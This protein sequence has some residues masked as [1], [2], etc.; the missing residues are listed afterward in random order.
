MTSLFTRKKPDLY[1]S[2]VSA[3]NPTFAPKTP[4]YTQGLFSSQV[5]QPVSVAPQMSVAP[6]TIQGSGYGSQYASNPTNYKPTPPPTTPPPAPVPTPMSQYTK[7]IDD[8]FKR[9]SDQ[10]A[11]RVATEEASRQKNQ[12]LLNQRY[13]LMNDSIRGSVPVLQNNF[14]TFK[15]NTQADVADTVA[16]GERQKEQTRDYYGEAERT[17]AQARGETQAQARQK[18]AAQGAVDSR[19]AGS[20]TQA[21]EN[22]DSD[23]NRY[24]QK[25]SKEMAMKLTDIDSAVGQYQRQASTLIQ[26]EEAKLQESL[27]QIEFT[28][29][30]NEIAKEQAMNEAYQASQTRIQTIQD[31]L[32]G[33]EQQAITQKQTVQLELDKLAKTKFTPEFMATGVP[34]TQA[35]YEFMV[36]NADKM[37]E[38]GILPGGSQA[39]SN[40]N[41]AL[42]M[43]NNILQGDTKNITGAM[44]TG[45]V[46]ILSTLTGAVGKQTDYD[47]LKSLLA[48]AE[49]GQLKGSGTVSDFE[50]KML[51]KAAMAGL[52]QNLPDDEFRRRLTLLQQDLMSGGATANNMSM[53]NNIITAPDGQQVMIVD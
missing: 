1:Q 35:E 13:G 27:R 17:A 40:Q 50:A 49:R 37:K 33:I 43:V 20:Y 45:S 34:T 9:M 22:I 44:R 15:T 3:V 6:K 28:L 10:S 2:M 26:T 7:T 39:G 41:K 14:N 38:L 36:T 5:R 16:Q 12:E 53:A 46:P 21:N 31:T 29:A 51:E 25:N 32:A 47:G 18:F 30:D 4:N 42:T 11:Q 8:Y 24:V 52:N 23:F 19:G 48:L